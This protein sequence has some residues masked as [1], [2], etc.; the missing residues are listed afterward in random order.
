MREC[1]GAGRRAGGG[2]GGLG[3]LR[4]GHRRAAGAAARISS[5]PL[6]PFLVERYEGWSGEPGRRV[7][8]ARRALALPQLVAMCRD[9]RGGEDNGEG[10]EALA[11]WE[12]LSLGY[13][14]QKG[15]EF[16]REDICARHYARSNLNLA[17][18]D[19]V[20]VCAPSEGIWLAMHAMLSPG[21]HVVCVSPAYQSLFQIAESMGCDVTP[22]EAELIQAGNQ[23]TATMGDLR[24]PPTASYFHFDVDRLRE[25]V[26][27]GRTKA[28]IVQFPQAEPYPLLLI[29]GRSGIA[30][31]PGHGASA[32]KRT[33]VRTLPMVPTAA[34]ELPPAAF[35][36]GTLET[37][38]APSRHVSLGGLSKTLG[39]PGLRIGW[40]ATQDRALMARM[41]ELRDY[42]TIC[43]S[44]P[45][46]ALASMALRCE[47][48]ILSAIRERVAK[49]LRKVKILCWEIAERRRRLVG[50]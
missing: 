11:R 33:G 25:L 35:A 41:E 39:L 17:S 42:T 3:R 19:D 36:S 6:P 9:D 50:S 2:G 43:S 29:S 16:L 21:D 28:V 24:S 18:L 34:L 31:R 27:P 4:S 45:S 8:S 26:R 46:E 38:A 44:A 7:C 23:G 20:L 22:W 40:L 13:T 49:N 32:T 14:H 10:A 1:C 5:S 30:T 37:S 48:R 47:G 12:R 15:E